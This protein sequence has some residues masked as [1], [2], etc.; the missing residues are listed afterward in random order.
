MELDLVLKKLIKKEVSYQ[1]E[2]LGLN[3]LITRV[4]KKYFAKQTKEELD[5]CLEEVK[6]FFAKYQRI[7]AKD[8]EKLNEL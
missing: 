5:T 6:V 2:N 7:M 1:S 4:Q 8:I 3:L